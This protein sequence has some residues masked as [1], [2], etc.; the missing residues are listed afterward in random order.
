VHLGGAGAG[1]E[2]LDREAEYLA[3]APRVLVD[4]ESL[5]SVATLA[6]L[7][8]LDHALVRDQLLFGIRRI[9]GAA[10]GRR[11]ADGTGFWLAPHLWYV[12]GLTRDTDDMDYHTIGDPY[13]VAL[14]DRSR[15]HAHRVFSA[16]EVD[17]VFVEDGVPAPAIESVLERLFDMYDVWGPGR[18]EEAAFAGLPSVRV[19]LHDHAPAEPPPRRAG[20]PEPSYEEISRARILQI[21]LDRGAGEDVIDPSPALPEEEPTFTT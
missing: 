6:E 10:T 9:L 12:R 20:Y 8:R 19:L 21:M 11:F 13:H 17:L 2:R 1:L 16:T 14:P 7:R 3:F 18:I 4:P 5:T 15:Q